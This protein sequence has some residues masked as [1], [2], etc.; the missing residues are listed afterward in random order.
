MF[1]CQDS[2]GF[3]AQCVSIPAHLL[4]FYRSN[5]N[6]VKGFGAG[7]P[8]KGVYY[9]CL[10]GTNQDRLSVLGFLYR[11]C[12]DGS[13][14]GGGEGGKMV[15]CWEGCMMSIKGRL[16]RRHPTLMKE[17][18]TCTQTHAHTHTDTKSGL[19]M[20]LFP[21][22]FSLILSDIRYQRHVCVMSCLPAIVFH[23]CYFPMPV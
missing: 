8:R 6:P 22:L 19:N 2:C 5:P 18:H 7:C 9:A 17:T 23:I 15:S 20:S 16:R 10:I 1:C 3:L 4:P 14:G 13:E 21:T 11:D 12:S